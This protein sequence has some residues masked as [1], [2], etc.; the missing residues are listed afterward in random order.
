MN[1]YIGIFSSLMFCV[2]SDVNGT[3]AWVLAH[4]RDME[5]SEWPQCV[6]NYDDYL[7]VVIHNKLL[8][9]VLSNVQG[10]TCTV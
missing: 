4:V 6:S 10:K 7:G 3:C 2:F 5:G 1:V 8:G 9:D